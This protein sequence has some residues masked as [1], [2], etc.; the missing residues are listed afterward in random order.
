MSHIHTHTHTRKSFRKK[1]T[2]K[3]F[4]G[5]KFARFVGS[6]PMSYSGRSNA[7]RAVIVEYMSDGECLR[8]GSGRVRGGG[9]A[10]I[11]A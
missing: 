1:R 3:A 5:Q 4:K 9:V 10:R 2:G 6:W 11:L 8:E 7:R